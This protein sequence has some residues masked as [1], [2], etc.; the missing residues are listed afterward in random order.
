MESKW[1]FETPSVTS[2]RLVKQTAQHKDVY[3]AIL[4]DPYSGSYGYTSR[5]GA[6]Y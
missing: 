4:Y 2:T 1:S 6:R 5:I 3:E